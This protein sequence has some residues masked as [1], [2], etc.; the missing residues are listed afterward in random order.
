MTVQTFALGI[1]ILYILVGLLGFVPA[2][3]SPA[4]SGSPSLA[5]AAGYGYLLSLFPVNVLHNL[6]HLGI[7]LWGIS[8]YRSVTSA[9]RFARGLAWFYGGLAVMGLVP[10]LNTTFGL[11]P[12]FGHDIWLHALTATI[13]AYYGWG[14]ERRGSYD[15][16]MRRVR[17]V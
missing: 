7:G 12:I 10:V 5:V 6:V 9:G 14:A 2:A 16:G 15:T 4:P 3:L 13:A 8:A 17:D 1:A 11:I